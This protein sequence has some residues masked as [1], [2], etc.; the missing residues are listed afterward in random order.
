[1]SVSCRMNKCIFFSGKFDFIAITDLYNGWNIAFQQIKKQ[2][3][4]NNCLLPTSVEVK[5]Q[6]NMVNLQ[7]ER[8]KSDMRKKMSWS[9]W[10]DIETVIK[11]GRGKT[12]QIFFHRDLKAV[13]VAIC[14]VKLG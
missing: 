2:K 12:L 11:E 3:S 4:N 6:R 14:I 9:G 5:G 8:F 1:M 7:V 13:Y 10:L